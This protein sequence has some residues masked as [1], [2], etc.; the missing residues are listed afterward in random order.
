MRNSRRFLRLRTKRK[1]M[2]KNRVDNKELAHREI[3]W[4]KVKKSFAYFV[5]NYCRMWEKEGG[6]PIPF[7]LYPFQEDAAEKMQ[8]RLKIIFLKARQMGLS[9]LASAY[10]LW[11]AMTRNNFHVYYTSIGLKEVQEQMNR[12]RFIFHGLP[13]WM[14]D[15]A[16]LG[17]KDCKDNDQ[18]IEFTNGS[19]IHATASG[20]SGGHGAAPGL[21]ICDEWSRVE[22]AVFKWRAIKPSASTKT[23]IFLIST[24]NG[25][26]NHFA[27]MWTQ[28]SAGANGFVPVFYSWKEHPNYTEEYVKEQENDFA[29]DKQG[30]LEAFPAS[31]EDAFMSSSR[32]VFDIE[33]IRQWKEL[34]ANTGVV[35][36]T[37][38]LDV[39][40]DSEIRFIDDPMGHLMVWKKPI[41][42]H[43]YSIGADVAT[44]IVGGDYSA[45]AVLD[46]DTNE[47]VALYRGRVKTEVYAQPISL[48]GRWYNRAF[49]AV[50]V[51]VVSD[52]VISDLKYSYQPLYMRPQRKN[53]TDIPTLVPGF[54]TSSSSKPRIITQL[55][56]E[57]SNIDKPL[58][59]YSDIILNEMSTYEQDEKDG[60]GASQGHHDDTVMALAIAVEAKLTLPYGDDDYSMYAENIKD[61]RSL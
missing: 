58:R 38:Y 16:T 2:A 8:H 52:L 33:R 36:Q 14:Q 19:A 49:V 27:E 29:G 4:R 61:W 48:A 50:E 46:C 47:V 20:K 30:F 18:L 42:G 7:H 21:I 10:S 59:I 53:I 24:S 23:Q 12:I 15:K 32:S 13:D 44:G 40:D 5:Y 25:F 45:F 11:K 22:D 28:A 60:L 41:E 55:R 31:P 43:Q 54:Y 56:R 1:L 34:V 35:F 6:D 57:F 9:W 26:G 51:N 3:E 37:G 39:G 17:G